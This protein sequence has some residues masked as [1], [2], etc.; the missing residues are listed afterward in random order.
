MHPG[1]E[2]NRRLFLILEKFDAGTE[3]AIFSPSHLNN[4]HE[5]E[6]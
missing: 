2:C 1:I 6:E 4:S 5:E 3:V